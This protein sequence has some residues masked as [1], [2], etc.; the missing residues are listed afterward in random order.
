MQLDERPVPLDPLEL[1]PPLVVSNGVV[2][3]VAGR[4]PLPEVDVHDGRTLLALADVPAG[5]LECSTH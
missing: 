5:L 1:R 2:L 3:L 4:A